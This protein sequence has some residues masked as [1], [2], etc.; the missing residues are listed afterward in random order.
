VPRL[1]WASWSALIRGSVRRAH[2]G[3]YV[4]YYLNVHAVLSMNKDLIVKLPFILSGRER[5]SGA[6]WGGAALPTRSLSWLQDVVAWWRTDRPPEDAGGEEDDDG[7]AEGPSAETELLVQ[8][9]ASLGFT[10]GAAA[11]ALAANVRAHA[12]THRHTHRHTHTH[13]HGPPQD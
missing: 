1:F 7:A 8:Q 6:P 10:Q 11:K 5:K 2:R 3:V 12:P 9:L 4:S 13:T